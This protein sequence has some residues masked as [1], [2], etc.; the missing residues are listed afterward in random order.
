MYFILK[1]ES[2]TKENQKGVDNMA[3]PIKYVQKLREDDPNELMKELWYDWNCKTVNDFVNWS[4]LSGEV[5]T[6]SIDELK[7]GE[8]VE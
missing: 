6:Y 8:Q 7:E 1:E 2:D 5:I 3:R 4:E